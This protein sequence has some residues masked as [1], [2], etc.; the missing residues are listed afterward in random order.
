MY[1][2]NPSFCHMAFIVPMD[3]VFVVIDLFAVVCEK[4]DDGV[5]VLEKVNNMFDNIIIINN[6]IVIVGNTLLF[7]DVLQIVFVPLYTISG[8]T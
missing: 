5:L 4:H 3:S 6:S 1:V 2:F 7:L 8:V